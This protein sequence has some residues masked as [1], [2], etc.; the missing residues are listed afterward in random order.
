MKMGFIKKYLYDPDLW[1][2]E[3]DNITRKDVEKVI[4]ESIVTGDT[5][6]ANYETNQQKNLKD[7]PLKKLLI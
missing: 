5:S 2:T 3:Y 7:M 6:W 1:K 4:K